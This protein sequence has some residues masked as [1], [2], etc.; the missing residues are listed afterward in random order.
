MYLFMSFL[1]AFMFLMMMITVI[2]PI[3]YFLLK[4]VSVVFFTEIDQSKSLKQK[5][6]ITHQ[7]TVSQE[8]KDILTDP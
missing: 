1:Q 3:I 5:L 4:N 2:K 6:V 8:T 7:Y